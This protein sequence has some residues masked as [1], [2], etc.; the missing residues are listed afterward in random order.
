MSTSGLSA[1]T[2]GIGKLIILNDYLRAGAPELPW[3]YQWS[4]T[5]VVES[6]YLNE[7]HKEICSLCIETHVIACAQ[8]VWNV[9]LV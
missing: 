3:L 4:R 5:S 7:T 9:S 8:E 6:Y 2:D 1:P